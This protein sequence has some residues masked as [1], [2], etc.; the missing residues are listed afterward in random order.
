MYRIPLMGLES[1]AHKEIAIRAG[2]SLL[3]EGFADRQTTSDGLLMPRNEPGAVLHDGDAIREKVL[4]LAPHVDSI[5]LHGDTPN[6]L[7]FAELVF[8]TLTDAGFGVGVG[9]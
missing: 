7:E 3:R 8:K 2:Q 5:C 9:A 1:T 6:C 4:A